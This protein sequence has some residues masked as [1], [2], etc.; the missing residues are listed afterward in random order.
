[1][2]WRDPAALSKDRRMVDEVE[3]LR[4]AAR[5]AQM[6]ATLAHPDVA[7]VLAAL[8]R[9]PGTPAALDELRPQTGLSL[10]PFGDAIGR[11]LDA[12]VLTAPGPG[13]IAFDAEAVRAAIDGL[14]AQS[15]LAG[16]LADPDLGSFIPWG[17]LQGCPSD[18]EPLDRLCRHV[19]P[20]FEAG[21]EYSEPSVNGVLLQVTDDYAGLRRVLVDR[22]VLTRTPDG[23][24][25]RVA[26]GESLP[27]QPEA[28]RP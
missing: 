27:V 25:Y 12:G 19:L 18:P 16:A 10:R 2:R 3:R 20:L 24:S 1:M 17:R 6:L 22:G 7:A 9:R 4:L 28:G 8:P 11:G 13:R 23:S 15:P 26:G 14:V 5:S 21:R